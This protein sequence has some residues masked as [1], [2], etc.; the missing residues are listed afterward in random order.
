MCICQVERQNELLVLPRGNGETLKAFTLYSLETDDTFT[1]GLRRVSCQSLSS[2]S[3][4]GP[5][6]ALHTFSLGVGWKYLFKTVISSLQLSVI[7][8]TG[9]PA[10]ACP[11]ARANQRRSCWSREAQRF[12]ATF[13]SKVRAS[14]CRVQLHQLV[15]MTVEICQLNPKYLHS[16]KLWAFSSINMAAG[17]LAGN[18]KKDKLR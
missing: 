5:S 12:T 3:S 8:H 1:D 15:K 11:T 14:S 6:D 13:S 17:M 16:V 18:C 4:T 2:S 9:F 10:A 7:T